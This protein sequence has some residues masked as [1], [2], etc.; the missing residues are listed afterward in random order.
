MATGFN[1][2]IVSRIVAVLGVLSFFLS[3]ELY[4]WGP[5]GE[6]T[7]TAVNRLPSWQRELLAKIM[8]RDL[9]YS[10]KPEAGDF[11]EKSLASW[12]SIYCWY[13]D[14]QKD[15]KWNK[16]FKRWKL[17]ED[18]PDKWNLYY[19]NRDPSTGEYVYGGTH[20]APHVY[21]P[22]KPVFRQVIKE[23]RQGHILEGCKF[24]GVLSH[25][26]EDATCPSHAVPLAYPDHGVEDMPFDPSVE[27]ALADYEPG[28]LGQD[29]EEACNVLYK[30][31]VDGSE[32]VKPLGKLMVD[33]RKK[34]DVA[35]WHEE[36]AKAMITGAKIVADML[37]TAMA[38]SKESLMETYAKIPDELE[39]RKEIG[40]I[41]TYYWIRKLN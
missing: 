25:Y 14:W 39:K 31:V 22:I 11:C 20:L 2:K 6:I 16:A 28:L 38:L 8:V 4:A 19:Y 29:V 12:L 41:S 23:W 34:G 21:R 24:A 18:F 36:G 1:F 10:Q 5:H 37:H 15:I 40:P 13:P 27:K 26:I 9:V 35:A 33:A 3:G 17:P 30:S 32:E 7:A